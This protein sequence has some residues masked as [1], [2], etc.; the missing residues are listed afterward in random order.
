MM[1]TSKLGIYICVKLE[2]V[3][4]VWLANVMSRIIRRDSF[5]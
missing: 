2:L 5:R 4:D 1:N 3:P